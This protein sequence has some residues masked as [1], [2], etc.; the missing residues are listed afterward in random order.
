MLGRGWGGVLGAVGEVEGFKPVVVGEVGAVVAVVDKDGKVVRVAEPIAEPVG[1]GEGV[2]DMFGGN[3]V[4]VALVDII[5]VFG[6]AK[7]VA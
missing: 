2:K 4:E 3:D 7:V 1:F 6:G 5:T